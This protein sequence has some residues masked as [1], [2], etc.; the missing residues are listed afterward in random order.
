MVIQPIITYATTKT[1]KFQ[2]FSCFGKENK[3]S[4]CVPA[5]LLNLNTFFGDKCFQSLGRQL[6]TAEAAEAFSEVMIVKRT[7]IP[8]VHF[9][10]FF[11]DCGVGSSHFFDLFF[12]GI[13]FAQSGNGTGQ[14]SA[15][16]AAAHTA[17]ETG[18]QLGIFQSQAQII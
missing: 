9:Q 8:G 3:A 10:R 2:Y 7:T 6:H 5:D 12:V 18:N 14:T 17:A 13:Q 16:A 4:R 15:G 11:E 1:G